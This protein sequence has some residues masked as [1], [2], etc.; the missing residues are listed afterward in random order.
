M[1][2]I[3]SDMGQKLMF[4]AQVDCS[5]TWQT[6]STLGITKV[7]D[8]KNKAMFYRYCSNTAP[9]KFQVAAQSPSQG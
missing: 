4:K 2:S 8:L 9:P 6:P 5:Q 3:R 7:K 1:V